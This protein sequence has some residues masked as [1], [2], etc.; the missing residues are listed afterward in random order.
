MTADEHKAREN[1][2]IK[3]D[4]VSPGIATGKAWLIK[5]IDLEAL[6]KVK[7][8]V[9]DI[10]A[11]LRRFEAAVEE[12]KA[13]LRRI[14]RKSGE[15]IGL[16]FHSHIAILEDPEFLRT[17]RKNLAEE[18]V[19]IEHI[20]ARQI[21]I[22]EK[23]FAGIREETLRARFLDIQDVCHR[24]LRNLLGI[25]HVRV[26]PLSRIE[27]AVILV[28]K[29]LVTSDIALLDFN[30]ILGFVI[31][32]GSANSHVAI[33]ARSI[34][35]PTLIH[36][37]GVSSLIKTGD[38]LI[39]D[40]DEAT[41]WI[42]PPESVLEQVRRKKRRAPAKPSGK[43][44]RG[45]AA[46]CMT[47]DGVHIRIEANV[48]T[49]EEAREAFSAG[50]E[51]IGLL[52]SE[53][54]YM[55][56]S[57]MPS[58]DEE[59]H[60]YKKILAAAAGRP[61]TVRV[62][63]LGA[64]KS[65][66]YLPSFSEENPQLGARGIRFLFKFPR[67]FRKQLHSILLAARHGP[68]KILLPFVAVADD[69]DRALT[70]VQEVRE[71]SG[72]RPEDLPVGIMVEIPSMALAIDSVIEK[73]DFLSIGTNDLIQ[74]LFAVSRESGELESYRQPFHPVVLGLLRTLVRAADANRKEIS[75]CGEIASNPLG[76]SLLVGLGIRSLS[77]PP[78]A[79]PAVRR[80]LSR[81]R[82]EEAR[83]TGEKAVRCTS[84]QE[85]LE[86]SAHLLSGGEDKKK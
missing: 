67:L 1:I 70:A 34:G 84:Y 51:G 15:E 58:V 23:Q 72:V 55:T 35:V 12:S 16:I 80:Q 82:Y 21:K 75:V 31:E 37:P 28:A 71:L 25:E 79:I 14:G 77:M 39:L 78:K 81:L 68:V 56:R 47:L 38:D 18:R 2:R 27:S 65:L 46:K 24:L 22:L 20:I 6:E 7:F 57:S 9:D 85:V 26:N 17:L 60:F 43:E 19:N 8:P 45:Q 36:L 10:A 40:G 42:Q 61:L 64:D 52:R 86:R 48:N 30:R 49:I 11:E 13:Q 44:V 33:I 53:F 74:Y 54:Y 69:L 41:V 59:F 5:E 73:V 76:A 83:K 4:A 62:L 66:A 63:D 3:G 29:R 32:E 50:A